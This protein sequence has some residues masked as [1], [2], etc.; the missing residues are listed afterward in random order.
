[1]KIN[2][3]ILNERLDKYISDK[4]DDLSRSDIKRAIDSGNIKVNG[5]NQKPSYKI[6]QNDEIT[7][8]DEIFSIKDISPENIDIKI[9]YE[10][11]DFAVINKDKDVIVHP[12][13]NIV[14]GTL[15]NALLYHF[16]KLSDLSGEDRKGIV[17]RLDR[18]TTGL[19]IIAKNNKIHQI[20]KEKFKKR[21]I[22]KEYITIV[23]G[24]FYDKLKDTIDKPIARSTTNRKKMA[25]DENGR[26]AITNYEVIDQVEGFAL[27]KVIIKTGR[28]HQIRVHMRSINHPVVGDDLYCNVKESFNTK[29]QILHC[30]KMAFQIDDKKY[31]FTADVDD[32]FKHI[33]EILKLDYNKIKD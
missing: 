2:V 13:G 21:E 20:L 24:N 28:T 18:N 9:V 6:K 27:V 25:I 15:E 1:M 12:S 4:I 8:N 10:N 11:E 26:K 5:K 7:I 33:L 32:E 19:I 23:H 30:R 22:Y 14:S 16:D 31:E 17:H 3:D 29:G